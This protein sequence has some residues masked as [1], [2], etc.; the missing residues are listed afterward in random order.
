MDYKKLEEL[1]YKKLCEIA[2]KL[3]IPIKRSKD[4]MYKEIKNVFKEYETYKKTKIDKYIKEKEIKKTKDYSIY[5]VENKDDNKKYIMK[6]FKKNKS[7]SSL[8]REVELQKLA[9]DFDIA[10]NIVDIDTVSKYIIM[11]N[12]D[13]HINLSKEITNKQQKQIISILKKLDKSQVY[14][15][16]IKI[17][18]FM[19]KGDN[20]SI[21]NFSK[22][23][24]ITNNL[25]TKYN[26][27]TPNLTLSSL[28]L[29]S[30]LKDK[31]FNKSSYEL[32][33]KYKSEYKRRNMI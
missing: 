5:L 26:T 10:P 21:I 27:D 16:N 1:S 18:N 11:E 22:S 19:Y 28:S 23:K 17:E 6:S 12:M 32:L 29:V 9:S 3:E 14:H 2:N 13:K 24:P 31:N 30:E 15:D 25:I 33:L 20:L 8:N 4:S 7:S